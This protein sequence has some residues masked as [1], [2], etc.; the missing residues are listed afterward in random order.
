M[1]NTS[2]Q[3]LHATVDFATSYKR[4]QQWDPDTTAASPASADHQQVH[5]A[6][7]ES[8][9]FVFADAFAKEDLA[10]HGHRT[11]KQLADLSADWKVSFVGMA[12]SKT[13]ATLTDWTADPATLHFSGEAIYSRD[14]TLSAVPSSVFLA[15]SGGQPLPGS[16]NSPPEHEAL[17]ANG[18]P[19][20]LV[21]R[22]GPGMH[23]YFDPPIREAALVTV[24]GQPA[25]ALWHPP[26]Q[27]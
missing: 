21:T 10:R 11:L 19:N 9:V 2:N 13:E 4:A 6:P 22:P 12:D 18:L 14:F 23:A 25:G 15:V 24:N 26:Y 16:P 7:Y 20:P 1:V 5:L 8:R 27:A 3:A 17:G